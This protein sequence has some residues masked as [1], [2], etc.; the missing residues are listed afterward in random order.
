MAA[1]MPMIATTIISSIKVKPVFLDISVQALAV[2]V[3]TIFKQIQS[4][5]TNWRI[6]Y[7]L[8]G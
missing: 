3:Y 4:Q 6:D 1:N 7:C 2:G 5:D 8:E